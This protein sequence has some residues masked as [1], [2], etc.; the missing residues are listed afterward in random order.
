MAERDEVRDLLKGLR[1]AIIALVSAAATA[2]LVIAVFG[3]PPEPV[4]NS[5]YGELTYIAEAGVR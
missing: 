2:G 1:L 4:A 3:G 5:H